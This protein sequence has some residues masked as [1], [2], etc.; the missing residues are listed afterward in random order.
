MKRLAL[1]AIC[2][3]VVLVPVDAHAEIGVVK[4]AVTPLKWAQEVEVCLVEPQPSESCVAPQ[5]DGSYALVVPEGGVRVEFLPSYRSGL[6]PQYY[7]HKNALREA[8]VIAVKPRA[9]TEGIDADLIAGGVIAGIVTAAQ[10]G[11]RLA[12]VEVC[13]AEIEAP[14]TTIC[15]PTDENGAYELHSLA[16]GSYRVGFWGG[17]SSSEF[18]P[19]YYLGRPSFRQ[20]TPVIVTAG[21]TTGSI[22][23]SLARGAQVQGSVFA[24]ADGRP[25]SDISVCIFS[26]IDPSPQRCTD[27][28]GTGAYAF[29]G[30]GAGPYR[31]GFSL[32]PGEPGA[33]ATGTDG[34]EQQFYNK[35]SDRDQAATI[36]VLPGGTAEG[37]DAAL[38]VSSLRLSPPVLTPGVAPMGAGVTPL[39]SAAQPPACKPPARRKRVKG[40]LRCVRGHKPKRSG[41]P[42]HGKPR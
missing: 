36:S 33:A 7:D 3:F 34:F 21:S 23:A 29:D 35:V 16:S 1:L 32:D 14:E 26:T 12:E 5:L 41:K 15:G 30:L 40:K 13:A 42:K 39:A 22:D 28:D 11:A 18:E 25:L 2:W 17:G 37:V 20:G 19:W 4:G 27:S 9:V 38:T 24:A 31:V 8:Q 10:D 6:L